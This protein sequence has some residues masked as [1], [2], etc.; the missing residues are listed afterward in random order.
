MTADRIIELEHR[1]ARLEIQVGELEE[2]IT[3]SE[4]VKAVGLGRGAEQVIS[5]LAAYVS[6]V[7]D[8]FDLREFLRRLRSVRGPRPVRLRVRDA[9]E[10]FLK[11][12]GRQDQGT[13]L[14]VSPRDRLGRRPWI[15][16]RR[17]RQ[18]R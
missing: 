11:R 5:I 4:D 15:A 10:V 3:E 2:A 12:L 9:K 18:P 1:I 16:L 8:G 6:E 13:D 7:T 14:T 17:W